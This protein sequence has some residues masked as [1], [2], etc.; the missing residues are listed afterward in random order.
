VSQEQLHEI[1]RRLAGHLVAPDKKQ[2][3]FN[4]IVAT[5]E[6]FYLDPTIGVEELTESC[7]KTSPL[8]VPN[9]PM[10]KSLNDDYQW[11]LG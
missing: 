5:A 1:A 9:S 11:M 3:R 4:E 7:C 6:A 8:Y 2:L 10:W